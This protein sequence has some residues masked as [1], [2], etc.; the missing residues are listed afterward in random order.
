MPSSNLLGLL[1]GSFDPV[2]LAHI[3]L[4]TLAYQQF[5]LERVIFIPCYDSLYQQPEKAKTLQAT[6]SQRIHMLQLAIAAIPAFEV[7]D[8]ECQSRT[9]SYTVDTLIAFRQQYPKAH[10]CFLLGEDAFLSLPTWYQWQ[11]IF[12]YAHLIIFPRAQT[13]PKHH[14]AYPKPLDAV[15]KTRFTHDKQ[16]LMKKPAGL[17]SYLETP[18]LTSSSTKV[19]NAIECGQI[20]WTH[21]PKSVATYIKKNQLYRTRALDD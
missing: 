14:D 18:L 12:D 13:A 6:P 10:L 17:I 11:T 3:K 1:G 8:Y 20:D 16:A 19:R 5:S 15:L 21:L 7:S 4:A 2:H 9:R